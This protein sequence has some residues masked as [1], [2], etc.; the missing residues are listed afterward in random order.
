MSKTLIMH[1]PDMPFLKSFIRKLEIA[2]PKILTKQKVL[3][4]IAKGLNIKWWR[5]SD[6]NR[7]PLHCQRSALA[8]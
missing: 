2:P 5:I 8:K 1:E 6:S 7:S 4:H 3:S